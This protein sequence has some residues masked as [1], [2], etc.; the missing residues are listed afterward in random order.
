MVYYKHSVSPAIGIRTSSLLA[1]VMKHIE[2]FQILEILNK[3]VIAD[4]RFFVDTLV[5]YDANITSM[6][7]AIPDII[8]LHQ[9]LQ[10]VRESRAVT[11]AT[12]TDILCQKNSCQAAIEHRMTGNKLSIEHN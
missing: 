6:N 2:R 12:T 7:S 9:T 5:I 10:L 3:N 11:K 1:D 4:Y 8:G